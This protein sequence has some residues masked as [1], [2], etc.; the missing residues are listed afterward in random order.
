[1]A[2]TNLSVLVNNIVAD[3]TKATLPN[4]E[5]IDK[6]FSKSDSPVVVLVDN[7]EEFIPKYKKVLNGRMSKYINMGELGFFN[8]ALGLADYVRTH[9]GYAYDH[10]DGA[11]KTEYPRGSKVLIV[12]DR[13]PVETI[14]VVVDCSDMNVYQVETY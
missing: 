6:V 14:D 10:R 7:I 5:I 8:E 3:A 1:M 9:H 4:Q 2:N 11:Q 13:D 12:G